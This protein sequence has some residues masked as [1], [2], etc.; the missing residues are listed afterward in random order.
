MSEGPY[1]NP[2]VVL[3]A[4]GPNSVAIIRSLGRLGIPVIACDHDPRALGLLSRWVTPWFTRDA[5][6][7]P[8]GFTEDVL[9][10]G[11]TLPAKGVLFPTHDEAIGALGPHEDAVA[12]FFHRPWSPW[13]RMERTMDKSGQHAAARAIGFPVPLTVEPA[14]A[15]DAVA[16]S[17]DMRFPVI[18]KPRLS[19]DF[20][21]RF[22]TQVLECH[23]VEELRRNWE[24]AA[25][26]EPQM[27]EVIPG[28]DEL[29][30]SLGSYRGAGGERWASFT[31]RKLRQYPTR[32]GTGRSAESHWDPE[33]AER[34]H[35]LLDELDFQG[36]SQLETKRDPRDGRDHLIEV[37]TRSWLWVGLATAVGVNLPLACYLDAIGS[38]RQWPEGHRDGLRWVLAT[39]HVGAA[40][41]EIRRGQWTVPEL[42][43]TLRPPIREGVWDLRDLRPGIGQTTRQ[44]RAIAGKLARRRGG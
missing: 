32:F 19:P 38:P 9:N 44:M 15:A 17:A 10:L 42:L 3:Q 39:R 30:W 7:D 5:L 26:Y 28:G 1:V 12:Q 33:Y 27:S 35:A 34:C 29:I 18:L 43:K 11:R 2:A 25:P 16:L 31:G 13:E 14:D 23:D 21:K 40:V 6:A 24:L 36:I 4:S 8:E 41:G 37:N 22:K 20:R